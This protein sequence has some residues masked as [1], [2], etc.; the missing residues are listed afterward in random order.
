MTTRLKRWL[1]VAAA[2]I[3]LLAGPG[4]AQ[5]WL[6]PG[7]TTQY[8]PEGGVW[9][10]GFWNLMVRSYYYHPSSC[11]GSTAEFWD[12]FSWHRQ[13]SLNTQPGYTSAAELGGYN[14]WYTDDRYYY[15]IV[16]PGYCP[17]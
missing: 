3:S 10:Y 2:S 6:H 9:T 16:R 5:A 13:R 7:A 12:G 17:V 4:P 11:H 8:P 1:A 15:R 14:L